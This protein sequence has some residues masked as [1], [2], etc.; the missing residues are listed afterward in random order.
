[1]LNTFLGTD[2]SPSDRLV[3]NGG[4]ATGATR[5][6]ITNTD[7]PGAQTTCNGILV[8]DTINGDTTAPGAFALTGEVRGGAFD[9]FLFRGGLNGS[10]PNDWFLRSSFTVGPGPL[11]PEG[12]S[13]PP[14][15]PM[16]VVAE[17]PAAANRASR[18]LPIIGPELATYGVVQPIARQL[19]LTQLGTLHE[20]IGDTLTA[21]YPEGD[22]WECRSGW[23]RFFGQQIDD[24]YQAFADPRASGCSG[25]GRID[26]WRGSCFPA[27]AMS[28]AST[29]PT[30]RRCG[31]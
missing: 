22:G 7:G 30:E 19:G 31:H 29:S 21:A 9:Y 27:I 24:R 15:P 23:A 16:R 18:R 14:Q 5:L 1:M 10:S 13:V 11:P 12:K 26:L 6:R 3:I 8:M 25:S 20:R 4:T 28:S 17:R 2:G